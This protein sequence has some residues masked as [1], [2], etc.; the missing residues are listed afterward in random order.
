MIEK[1]I[2]H[3]RQQQEAYLAQ[4]NEF[5]RFPSVSTQPEHKEDVKQT[6]EWLATEMRRIGLKDVQ[7]FPTEGSPVVYG[8]WLEAGPGIPTLLVYGHYDVQP[9]EPLEAWQSPP[10]EPTLRDGRI[11]ARGASDNKGQHFSHLKAIES[12]LTVNGRLPLNIK[13][14]ID[15]EEE[16]GS[17]NLPDFVA[18]NKDLLAADSVVISDGAMAG[19]GRP[20]I[21]YACR[22]VIDFELHIKGPDRDLHSGSY[23]GTVHNPGQAL[24][25][26]VAALHGEDGRVAVPGFYDGVIELTAEERELLARVDYQLPQWQDD[27]GAKQPWGEPEH[28]LLERMTARPTLEV[29]GMWSGYTGD[30][31]KT[32]IPADAHLKFSCRLVAAQDPDKIAEQVTGYIRQIAPP[33]VDIEVYSLIGCQAAVAP[34]QGPEVEAAHKAL[35]ETWGVEAVISRMGGT[36]PVVAEFQKHLGTPFVLVP[37]GLDDNRHSPNEHYRLDYLQRGIESAIRYYYHLA[38]ALEYT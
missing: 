7:V 30:G 37:F 22:G 8:Q 24:A 26:I 20:S 15:G 27:T 38:K 5:L 31:S 13:V 23:G 1:A 9:P 18:R 19:E 10:F 14:C 16:S 34:F 36:L 32:I 33:T 11:Y 2:Q 21:Q 6:A 3:T 17:P 25:E 12:I 4:F 28:T 29:N 35:S